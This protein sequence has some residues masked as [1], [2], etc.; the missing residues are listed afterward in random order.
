MKRK[1]LK[2]A[3]N[4][5]LT[6]SIILTTIIVGGTN[7]S[8]ATSYYVSTTGN[9]NN[10]GTLAS[11]WK[12]IQKAANTVA[13]GDTV[14]LM[15]GNYSK[16]NG[17]LPNKVVVNV[18][19]SNGNYITFTNYPGETVTIDGTGISLPSEINGVENW[20]GLIEATGKS[21]LKFIGLRVVNSDWA[22]FL[23]KGIGGNSHYI[24][25]QGCYIYNA[26]SAAVIMSG[27]GG[28]NT[29]GNFKVL[30]NEAD[31]C[32][33]DSTGDTHIQEVISIQYGVS[34]VEVANNYVHD[35]IN[36]SVWGGE[37][38]DI[39]NGTSNATV[40]HNE[41]VNT[42]SVGIY[43]DGFSA[44]QSNISVYNN[45]IHDV[46]GS[47]GLA[48]ASEAGGICEYVNVYN[49]IVYNNY[50]GMRIPSYGTGTTRNAKVTNNTFYANGGGMSIGDWTGPIVNLYVRN[51]IFSQNVQHTIV[52]RDRPGD[53]GK[54]IA[55]NLID[56]FRGYSG[57]GFVET[58]GTNYVEGNPYFVD[59]PNHNFRLQS[60]SPAINAGTS[61]DAPSFDYG[62]NSRPQGGGYDIGA[63]EYVGGGPPPTPGGGTNVAA[64]K[65]A[66]FSS[67]LS[68]GTAAMVTNGDTNTANYAGM[69][70]TG[71]QWA[72]IDFG[73]SYGV[74][75]V[76][77]WHYYG[78]GRTYHDVIVQLSNTADFSSGVTTVFNNDTN[79]SAGQGTGGNAEY[80][81]SSSGKEITFSTV[82]ARY[83]RLWTN[84]S[85]ANTAQHYVEVEVY[86][87]GGPTPTPANKA[88]GRT[89]TFSSALS[90]GTAAMV[91]NGDTN[92][93]NYASMWAAGAQWTK[94][95]LGASYNITK[96]K[97]WHYY[98]DGRTYR[99]VIVQ[100]SNTADFSSGVTT[101][102]N[103]DTNNSAGQGTG[104]NAE[105]AETSA[106]KE[107]TFSA[108][109]ARYAR[110]WT[111]G[112]SANAAHHYVE[113]EV[114]GN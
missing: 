60:N 83:V 86:S 3:F 82:N 105:Y 70:A 98:G 99:D 112:S 100:L 24:T 23:I 2:T 12:T 102:F 5:V 108:V 96:V 7:V 75:R 17:S 63:F 48:L 25:I 57:G 76:K 113:V 68:E 67:T 28:A 72:K 21:Y 77:V 35:Y 43:V 103:N 42:T 55:Y 30:G 20:Q 22:A 6:L 34:D 107:I 16:S 47:N 49:N 1:I 26:R 46:A 51:N 37:G 18:S 80:A 54:V 71:P 27:D 31:R 109:N 85:S 111:N 97:V 8:A 32:A 92:T 84:G 45:S 58:R 4:L 56:G 66:T 94:I 90:E 110:L 74:N 91:T 39:K 11:P 10:Q 59:G 88:A 13:A 93:A 69:W 79:N 9:D 89:P 53:S 62:G 106:G 81:E 64:G 104:G 78:D 61:T 29:S 14:Y 65:T 36:D 38:I 33:N 44:Y 40:H 73:A 41:V 101:V 52:N 87:A 15:G 19:G 114:W 95:D 50:E